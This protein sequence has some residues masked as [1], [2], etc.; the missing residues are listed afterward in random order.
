MKTIIAGS[1]N[2]INLAILNEAVQRS[3]FDITHVLSGGA[4]GID[5]LGEYWAKVRD[6]PLSIFPAEWKSKGKSAGMIR[7]IQMAEE[8]DALIA[9]WDGKSK[10]TQHMIDVAKKKGLMVYVHEVKRTDSLHTIAGIS[11]TV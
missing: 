11:H 6:V 9:V 1:R 10:G 4:R 2:I 7:N 3:A 8:A 5:K